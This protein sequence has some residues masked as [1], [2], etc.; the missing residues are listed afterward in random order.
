M[1]QRIVSATDAE[2]KKVLKVKTPFISQS[3]TKGSK[4]KG[5]STHACSVP[6]HDAETGSYCR[7]IVVYKMYVTAT[8]KALHVTLRMDRLVITGPDEKKS[9]AGVASSS[10]TVSVEAMSTAVGA[11][12]SESSDSNTDDDGNGKTKPAPKPKAR[13]KPIFNVVEFLSDSSS[14]DDDDVAVLGSTGKHAAAGGKKKA[15]P[16]DDDEPTPAP[17]AKKRAKRA[18]RR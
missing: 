4:N 6:G 14:D 8:E 17:A 5:P 15:P 9:L 1:L 18:P 13:A 2:M 11:W 16:S 7:V 10:G 3:P 12:E